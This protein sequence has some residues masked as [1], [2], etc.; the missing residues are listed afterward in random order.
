MFLAGAFIAVG[1]LYAQS[2][3]AEWQ[4]GVAKLKETIQTNPAQANEE[5]EQLIKGKNKKNVELLVAIGEVYLKAGKLPEAQEYAAL[6][7]K[8][9]GKSALASV[10]EGDIAFEQKNAGLASQKY[11]E[12]IYFDP[13]CTEAYLKNDFS[14][15]AEAYSRFAMGPTAT[16][17]DLVKYAFAL[18]LNHDFEKS[19]EVANMGLKKNARHAAFNRL[20]MYNYTDLKRF[21]EAIKAADAFFTESD[22]ADYSYLD[23][24]YYGHLLEALKKYDEAVEQYEKAI[25]LDP[26]K[27]DLYKNIS[28]AYEQKNDYKKAISAYQKYYTSLDKEHQ[29]PD[30]QFQFGRLYYGAGTQTD[31]LTINA[32]ERKQA[33]M[34]ADSVFH[35]IA[36]AAPDSYLGNFWR[37]RANSALDPETTLG[38]AKPFYEEVATLLESKNDP[39]YNSALIECYS[40][41]GY[42]Y[43]LAIENPALKAEAMANKEKSKEYW[44]KILAIDSTNATAKRALDGIK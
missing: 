30:L 23:Y 44:S 34:A 27:T 29:T 25:Q 12:A 8:V 21:D 3:D 43:L 6:A 42:Y 13:S 9:N 5:A 41:L 17:E 24:M 11:E 10:L 39:H 1:S 31:S 16:E 32:E 4:A 40:Y 35:S 36:E 19:L 7:K 18:F 15:A 14:K 20:T 26:T 33:L 28:S 22:K 38:L 2:S 37:A